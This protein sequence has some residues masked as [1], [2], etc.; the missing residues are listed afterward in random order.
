MIIFV[1][2]AFLAVGIAFGFVYPLTM[3][4]FY[5]IKYGRRVTLRWIL[6]EIGW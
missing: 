2:L 4:L 3:I 6:R 1:M 5:K